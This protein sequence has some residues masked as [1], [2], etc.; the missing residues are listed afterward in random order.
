MNLT[1]ALRNL[2]KGCGTLNKVNCELLKKEIDDGICFDISM[3]SE[4]LSPDRFAPK[5]VLE[6]NDYKNVCLNCKNHRY[7]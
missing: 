4:G 1:Q 3:V 7:D 6:I 2:L 5:E